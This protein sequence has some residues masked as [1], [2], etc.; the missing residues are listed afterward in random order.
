M[1][2]GMGLSCGVVEGGEGKEETQKHVLEGYVHY[3]KDIRH[4]CL[5]S[6]DSKLNTEITEDQKSICECDSLDTH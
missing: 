6:Y 3:F 1:W 5:N 2:V 4:V